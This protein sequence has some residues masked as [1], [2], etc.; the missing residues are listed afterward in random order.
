MHSNKSIEMSCSYVYEINFFLSA[1]IV[2]TLTGLSFVG[3]EYSRTSV[4]RTS[5]GP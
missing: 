5:L 3:S 1:R 2:H 4:A